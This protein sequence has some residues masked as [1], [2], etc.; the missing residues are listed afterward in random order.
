MDIEK[1]IKDLLENSDPDGP[2]IEDDLMQDAATALS[3]L[4]AE[5]KRLKSLLGKDGQDLWSKENQRADLLEAENKKLRIENEK[6]KG[7]AMHEAMSAA[8]Y[9]GELALMDRKLKQ[10]TREKEVAVADLRQMCVGGNTCCFC[11][12]DQN[13][14]KKGPNRKTVEPCWQ[15]RGLEEG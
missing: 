11:A 6:L 4:Q 13:C 5:V 7:R 12:K 9:C 10:V 14:E 1:L 8:N 3:T 2:C 15:W